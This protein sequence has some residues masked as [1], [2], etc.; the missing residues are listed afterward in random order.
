MAT[1]PARERP[2]AALPSLGEAM[3]ALSVATDFA[4][5]QSAHFGMR[6]CALAVRLADAMGWNE[7][8]TRQAYFQALLRYVGCNVESEVIATVVGDE[9]AMR[10]DFAGVD[11]ADRQAVASLVVKRLREAHAGMP[12]WRLAGNMH[13]LKAGNPVLLSQVFGRPSRRLRPAGGGQNNA[14][15]SSEAEPHPPRGS[16]RSEAEPR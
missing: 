11:T 12:A 4:M 8:E 15:A 16:Q 13:T 10:R 5:A 3:A 2:P 6:S 9:M 14:A 1:G 7:A